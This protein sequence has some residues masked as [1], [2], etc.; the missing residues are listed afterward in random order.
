MKVSGYGLETKRPPKKKKK[1]TKKKKRL[2]APPTHTLHFFFLTCAPA[3]AHCLCRWQE[4]ADSK[5]KGRGQEAEER[6]GK[7][8]DGGRG[9]VGGR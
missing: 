7:G 9:L 8:Q 5:T 1:T 3:L 2:F 6:G 4:G